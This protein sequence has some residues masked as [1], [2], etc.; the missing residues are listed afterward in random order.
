MTKIMT[1]RHT[2]AGDFKTAL[3]EHLNNDYGI[4]EC[5]VFDNT[6]W[7]ILIKVVAG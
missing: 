7:A 1:V 6:W 4:L 2:N 3:E 5:G